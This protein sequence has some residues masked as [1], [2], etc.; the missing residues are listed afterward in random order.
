MRTLRID[1]IDYVKWKSR[2]NQSGT[3]LAT[4]R[5]P[6]FRANTGTSAGGVTHVLIA[7]L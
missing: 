7:M 2:A 3:D 6:M 1:N 4:T 5:K